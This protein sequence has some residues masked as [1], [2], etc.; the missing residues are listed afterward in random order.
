MWFLP[1]QVPYINIYVKKSVAFE[2][3]VWKLYLQ[4]QLVS[5]AYNRQI[6]EAETLHTSQLAGGWDFLTLSGWGCA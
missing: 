2:R 1:N 3:T 6:W 4:H 5:G